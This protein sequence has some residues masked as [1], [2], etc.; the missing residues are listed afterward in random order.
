MAKSYV[1]F[2]TPKDVV[3]KALEALTVAADTGRIRKGAN[4]TTKAIES[5]NA[6]LVVIAEDVDPEEVVMHLPILC[7]EKNVP[8]CYAPTK[9]ELGAA[10]GLGVPCAAVAIEKPGN[11]AEI[12]KGIVEKLGKANPKAEAKPAAKPEAKAEHK[13][14]H[15]HEEKKPEAPAAKAEEKPAKEK[16]PKAKKEKKPASEA[17]AAKK[18]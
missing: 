10:A 9:K 17:P 14:E 15:K 8:Y 7:G 5:G 4:E 13:K 16:K 3:S 12:V 1:K 11:A 6:A 18:E 2:E